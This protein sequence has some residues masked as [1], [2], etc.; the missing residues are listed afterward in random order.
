MEN[1]FTYDLYVLYRSTFVHVSLTLVGVSESNNCSVILSI[2]CLCMNIPTLFCVWLYSNSIL[3]A[4]FLWSITTTSYT[5]HCHSDIILISY[6]YV[7]CSLDVIHIRRMD[8]LRSYR[9][10]GTA[11][12]DYIATVL[13]A[14]VV[15]E[16]TNVPLSLVT[17]GLFVLSIVMHCAFGIHTPVDTYLG[18]WFLPTKFMVL[19]A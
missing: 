8:A 11:L 6:V 4:F 10:H 18:M 3:S 12:F 1:W 19:L 17:I 13:S 2:L 14:F 5:S 16:L 9:F 15:T 7:Y